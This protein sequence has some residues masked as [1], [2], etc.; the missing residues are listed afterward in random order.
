MKRVLT[1]LALVPIALY[2][3]LWAPYWAFFAL[4][5]LVALLCFYEYA[6]MTKS[7]A[8]LGFVAGIF[9]LVLPPG[10]IP[11]LFILCALAVMCVPLRDDYMEPAMH[12]AA[13]LL[14]GIIYVFGSW[15]TAIL[16]HDISPYWL[17]FALVINWVGDTGAYYVGKNF[18][19]H[20][21]APV[22]SPGK[23]WEGTVGGAALAII[24]GCFFVPWAIPGTSWWIGG[25]LA[26]LGNTA[27]Q[28]GDLG[29]SALKRASGVKD[30]GK[31]LPGHGGMLDRVDS[32]MFSMPVIL[33]LLN[34]LK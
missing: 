2:A 1:A 7:F 17:L 15:K 6:T 19:K 32:S 28:L 14:L 22:V 5:A 26:L 20:K 29:E 33:A 18:G 16:L 25:T 21:L 10:S 13:M 34:I 3:V 31:L 4:V 12:R 11:I 27:G 9:L 8:P 30:S 23:T 24:F